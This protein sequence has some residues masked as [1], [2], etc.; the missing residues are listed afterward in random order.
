MN[1]LTY[2]NEGKPINK[3]PYR[4]HYVP[5]AKGQSRG[6]KSKLITSLNGTWKVKKYDTIRNVPED[7]FVARPTKKIPVPSCVQCYGLDGNQ[8][9]NIRYPIPF[10]PPFTPVINPAYHFRREFNYVASENDKFLVFNGVDSNFFLYVNGEFVGYSLIT[11]SVNEFNVT[12]YLKDGKNVIDLLVVKWCFG[13]YL[14]DQDKFRM[15]GIIRDVYLLERGANR[16]D[17]FR[18]STAIDGKDGIVSFKNLRGAEAVVKFNGEEKCVKQGETIEF[19]VEN[20]QLWNAE[21]PYLYDMEIL[22]ENEIIFERVGIREVKIVDGIFKINGKHVKLLGI[23][24]HDTHP[25][26]GQALPAGFLKSEL[27]LMKKLNINCIRTSHYPATTELYELADEMGFYVVDEADLE[28]HGV[29]HRTGDYEEANFDYVAT[30]ERFKESIL[31]REESLVMRDANR[32]CVIFWSLGN[33]SGF[34]DNFREAARF[35]KSLD[36]TRLV[37][38]EGGTSFTTNHESKDIDMVSVMYA[39]IEEMEKYLTDENET[40]P[41]FQCE[42]AHGMGNSPGDLNDYGKEFYKSDRFMGGCLWEWADH[43]VRDNKGNLIYGGDSGEYLH[44]GEFCVDGFVDPER[45][46]KRAALEMKKVYEPAVI[47]VDGNMM[48]ITSRTNFE[49]LKGRLDL[50]Y[51]VWDQVVK[52]ESKEIC[53]PAGESIQLCVDEFATLIASI[54]VCDKHVGEFEAV[55]EGFNRFEMPAPDRK[56][57]KPIIVRSNNKYY[58]RAGEFEYVLSDFN[59]A[60]ISA[61]KGGK[62]YLAEQMVPS[63]F[64]AYINNDKYLVPTRYRVLHLHKTRNEAVSSKIVDENSVEFKGIIVMDSVMPHVEYTLTYKFFADSVDVSF[65]YKVGDFIDYLPKVG[66]NFAVNKSFKNIKYFGFGPEEAYSDKIA[67]TYKAYFESNVDAEYQH[68]MYPQECGAHFDSEYLRL[69]SKNKAVE[70]NG[71]FSFSALP[72]SAYQIDEAKHDFELKK[73][74][75]TYVSIDYY[76]AGVGSG[77]CGPELPMQYRTPSS[78]ELKFNVR[79]E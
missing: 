21:N 49:P 26:F 37:H 55:R 67:C 28:A 12:K 43:A 54:F 61:K 1:F 35:V 7:F 40:R 51:K 29:M 14:E 16:I 11:H 69:E 17:D 8:Y 50:V 5:F 32:P 78:G 44:D 48:T 79:F 38:Y 75:A 13:S 64:R 66:I 52:A 63:I 33:E 53:V 59:C 46:V 30:D 57:C 60:L 20:A 65:D 31:L 62:E 68:D 56:E 23:N 39:P 72:Y 10:R 74:D 24:H 70:I 71:A 18:I 27:E 6:E 9:T 22:T 45:N 47:T 15:T 34:G 4:S 77:A 76:T 41:Y 36:N 42:Y 2:I 3:E 25:D 73:S 19:R 58:V